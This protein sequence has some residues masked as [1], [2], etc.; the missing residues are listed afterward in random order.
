MTTLNIDPVLFNITLYGQ[1]FKVEC[2]YQ[3]ALNMIIGFIH[4]YT[5]FRYERPE[6]SDWRTR[7]RWIAKDA[8]GVRLRFPEHQ[9]FWFHMSK[10]KPLHDYLAEKLIGPEQVTISNGLTWEPA[11]A[12]LNFTTKF[13][14]YDYQ[15][16][17]IEFIN[18]LQPGTWQFGNYHIANDYRD[19]L[20]GLQTGKGK[21]VLGI[22]DICRRGERVLMLMPPKYIE[23]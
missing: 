4:P 13:T 12:T 1:G 23:K 15:L 6:G 10:L 5:I 22:A 18:R 2:R 17:G 3:H 16:E 9:E 7:K 19:R 20:I 11:K 14:P 8:F 21:T